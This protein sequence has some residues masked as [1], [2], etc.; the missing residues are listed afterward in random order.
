M[1]ER[2]GVYDDVEFFVDDIS[3]AYR[4]QMFTDVTFALSDGVT[5]KTNR[6][7]LAWRS[8]YFA[9][10]LLG[11]KEDDCK[12][13][14]NCDSK[15]FQILLDYIWE[16]R[17]DLSNLE[18]KQ[19]LDLLENAQMISLKRL[20]ENIQDYLSYLLESGQLELDEYWV[21]LQFCCNNYFR[22]ILVSALKFID[23]NFNSICSPKTNFLKLSTDAIFTILGNE[24]RTAGEIDV[25]KALTLWL[26]NQTHPVERSTRVALLGLV[27]LAAVSPVDLL[28]VVRKSGFYEDVNICDALEKKL[29]IR[30]G[31]EADKIEQQDEAQDDSFDKLED[32]KASPRR[33]NSLV[34]WWRSRDSLLSP[35]AKNEN[36]AD[37]IDQTSNV[38][39]RSKAEVN[40]FGDKGRS[41]GNTR[42]P[43]LSPSFTQ[44]LLEIRKEEEVL[45]DVV[46]GKI[47]VDN[48]DEEDDDVSEE[49][50]GT[51]HKKHEDY[52]RSLPQIDEE[53][54]NTWDKYEEEKASPR[55]QNSLAKWWRSRDS[56]LS[57][58]AL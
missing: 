27:D 4:N 9:S 31:N 11:L 21:V 35:K 6:F 30:N 24:N 13:V 52:Y 58:K 19:L 28:R 16:G 38:R 22:K 51:R 32:E 8:Q 53:L 37:K 25:F 54:D 3:K 42:N 26:E 50:E 18:L 34:K 12:V 40:A 48:D 45:F 36:G 33:Q 2:N 41:L 39:M 20:A 47:E 44:S 46:E 56:L 5:M 10:K 29:S 17:V 43:N 7:M 49:E 1:V 14:M 57:P 55:R 23:A 15:I